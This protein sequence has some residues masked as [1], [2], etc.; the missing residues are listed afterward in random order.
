MHVRVTGLNKYFGSEHVVR[1]VSFDL[2]EGQLV[3][4][5]GPSGGGKTTILRLLAGLEE[6][7]SGEIVFH[8]RRMER[9]PPQKRGIGFVFQNYA[10]FRHMT[11]AEN[12]AFGLAVM[13]QPRTAVQERVA[14]LVALIGLAGLER[15]YPHQLSGGQRQRVAFARAIAPKPQLLLLDEPFAA[16]D[17]K[18]RKEL[19]TWLKETIQRLS[20]TSI[21]VTHDQ[22]E[23]VELADEIMVIHQGRLEQ[24]GSPW[25]IY[26]KPQSPFVASFI[27]ESNLL[28]DCSGLKGFEEAGTSRAMIRPEFIELT[29][30]HGRTVSSI[31]EEGVVHSLFF[32]GTVWEVEVETGGRRLS[33]YRSLELDPLAPGD[34][35]GILIHR[36]YRFDGGIGQMIENRGKL[37][38][39]G[40]GG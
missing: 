7:D 30:A 35:V 39:S 26:K 9:V 37:R 16:I 5:L 3:G 2:E 13:R 32:R 12:I 14:E 29:L 28:A 10:L 11:V 24:K 1:D 20:I 34:R 23:A 6:P 17:A 40:E 4:L 38:Q 19:R 27:G 15:R 8:G 18:V 36:L 31:E 21:F 25:D 33:A 22:E